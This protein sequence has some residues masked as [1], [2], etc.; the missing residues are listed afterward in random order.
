MPWKTT[1]FTQQTELSCNFGHQ[2]Q[3]LPLGCVLFYGESFL[4]TPPLL[5]FANDLDVKQA[6]T[7]TKRLRDIEN[8]SHTAPQNP[9]P[10]T[11]S[12]QPGPPNMFPNLKKE[13]YNWFCI[14]G[15]DWNEDERKKN[16]RPWIECSNQYCDTPWMHM[17]CA[18]VPEDSPPSGQWY[19]AACKTL[20]FSDR[21]NPGDGVQMDLGD[22]TQ[23]AE[24]AQ[25]ATIQTKSGYTQILTPTKRVRWAAF[26]TQGLSKVRDKLFDET[27]TLAS[28]RSMFPGKSVQEKNM[29]NTQ[30]PTGTL[31][32]DP[33]FEDDDDD[34]TEDE[35]IGSKK[36]MMLV[37]QIPSKDLAQLSKR[38]PKSTK[39]NVKMEGPPTKKAKA[40]PKASPP[41]NASP[42]ARASPQTKAIPRR[43][44]TLSVFPFRS[45]K[46]MTR[47]TRIKKEASKDGM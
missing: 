44:G 36:S 24:G 43:K 25:P 12:R 13:S 14:C 16:H 34:E 37:L 31:A 30:E 11:T 46:A 47:N 38:K 42:R 39:A 35:E 8:N 7:M 27:P 40:S 26:T 6:D 28:I 20:G 33:E 18:G 10:S 15:K 4:S 2:C 17:W 32:A 1:L 21:S 45:T 19:C 5:P 9:S 22:P 41:V 3:A 23:R 29:D